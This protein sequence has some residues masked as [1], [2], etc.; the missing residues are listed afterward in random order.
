MTNVLSGNYRFRLNGGHFGFR[1]HL[2]FEKMGQ[3]KLLFISV[4]FTD[5]KSEKQ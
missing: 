5:I 3:I 2:G 1:G 4:V